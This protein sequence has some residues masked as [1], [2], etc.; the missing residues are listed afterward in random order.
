MND[1][2]IEYRNQDK[3][4][5]SFSVLNPTYIH[6]L[7]L[8]AQTESDFKFSLENRSY[9]CP[10]IIGHASRESDSSPAVGVKVCG[11]Y[12]STLCDS[13]IIGNSGYYDL[14]FPCDTRGPYNLSFI[15]DSRNA[16]P[17]S[18][19]PTE[20]IND[21][22][23]DLTDIEEVET[24]VRLDV[25]IDDVGFDFLRDFLNNSRRGYQDRP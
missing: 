4:K 7:T 12:E 9:H 25:V 2:K 20:R 10:S 21:T 16:C 15:L 23:I 22:G 14:D 13:T 24:D 5:Q 18:F 1:S 3:S 6:E 11:Y 19:N 8:Y 17:M